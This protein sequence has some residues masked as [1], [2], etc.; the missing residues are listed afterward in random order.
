MFYVFEC[1]FVLVK[2]KLVV[3]L[4]HRLTSRSWKAE[5]GVVFSVFFSTLF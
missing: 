4:L 5:K 1:I 3:Q 2:K